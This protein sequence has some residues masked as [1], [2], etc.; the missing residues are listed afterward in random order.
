[1]DRMAAL[2]WPGNVRQLENF[3]AQAVVLAEGD[4]LSERDLFVDDPGSA[5]VPAS[6]SVFEADLPLREVERRHI[7][8]TLQRVHGN[9]TEAARVLGISVRCLQYKLKA[10]T[11][12][13]D[14]SSTTSPAETGLHFDPPPT[15]STNGRHHALSIE[16]RSAV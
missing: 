4:M 7:L 14:T 16:Q 2:P 1:M 12:A 5:H 6:G 13:A 10:Y 3:L 8:R 15:T 9:R 11:Q